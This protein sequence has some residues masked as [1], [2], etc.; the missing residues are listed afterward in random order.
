MQTHGEDNSITCLGT[1]NH[2]CRIED[3]VAP[4]IPIG[5]YKKNKRRERLGEFNTY[6][7][8][9]TRTMAIVF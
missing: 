7:H 5:I 3:K 6:F 1:P 4:E 9:A 8:P 2:S